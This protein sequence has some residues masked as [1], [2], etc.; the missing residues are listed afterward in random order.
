MGKTYRTLGTLF[1]LFAL[2]GR[3]LLHICSLPNSVDVYFNTVV[4]LGAAFYLWDVVIDFVFDREELVL[5]HAL[6][7]NA[8]FS[9]LL[10]ATSVS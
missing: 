2:F 3:E 1:W 7:L 8:I 4:Y 10:D 6:D 5:S 9:L